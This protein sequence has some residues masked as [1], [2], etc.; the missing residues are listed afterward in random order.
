MLSSIPSYKTIVS[1]IVA[2]RGGFVVRSDDQSIERAAMAFDD[3]ESRCQ[4]PQMPPIEH[5]P[6]VPYDPMVN[7]YTRFGAHFEP[8]EFSGVGDVFL[9]LVGDD[10][11]GLAAVEVLWGSTRSRQ[12]LIRA[13]VAAAPYKTDRRRTDA[14]KL[15]SS[16]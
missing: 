15:P 7:T 13:T 16:R 1:H 10:V 14:I 5:V 3:E 6:T 4:S 9:S 2:M 11:F 8:D 12:K